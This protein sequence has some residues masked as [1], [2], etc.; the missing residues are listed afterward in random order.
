[1][2]IHVALFHISDELKKMEQSNF[3]ALLNQQKHPRIKKEMFAKPDPDTLC[4]IN[5]VSASSNMTVQCY[6]E[7][8]NCVRGLSK[9]VGRFLLDFHLHKDIL[10]DLITQENSS[11]TQ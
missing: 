4:D 1:M 11:S 8:F 6:C 7:K 3:G 5:P 10:G 2:C 9:I